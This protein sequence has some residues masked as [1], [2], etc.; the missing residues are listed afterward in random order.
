MSIKETEAYFETLTV[1]Q[2]HRFNLLV[3]IAHKLGKTSEE[4]YTYAHTV[5]PTPEHKVKE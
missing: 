2:A 5:M 3:Q 1:A 4:A